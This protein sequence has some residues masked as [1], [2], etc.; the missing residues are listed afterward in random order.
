M[1]FFE[2]SRRREMSDICP[3]IEAALSQR[4]W[5]YR[6]TRHQIDRRRYAR[7]VT[8]GSA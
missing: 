2:T 3:L 1:N 7:M 6:P 4:Q 5:F 8:P